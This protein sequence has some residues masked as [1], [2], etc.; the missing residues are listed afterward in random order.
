MYAKMLFLMNGFTE[1]KVMHVTDDAW[2]LY[3]PAQVYCSCNFKTSSILSVFWSLAV[4]VFSLFPSQFKKQV[5]MGTKC[6]FLEYK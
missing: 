3:F 6:P 1:N 2:R 5:K 4:L